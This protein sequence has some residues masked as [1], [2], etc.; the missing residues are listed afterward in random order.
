MAPKASSSV[1]QKIAVGFSPGRSSSSAMACS[2]SAGWQS[3]GADH[4]CRVELQAGGAYGTPQALGAVLPDPCV[5]LVRHPA[6]DDADPAVAEAEQ[7]LAR[8]A[9]RR[10]GGR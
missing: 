7:V 6:V 9:D 5:G 8:P 10:R 1:W 3:P 4:V 2:P